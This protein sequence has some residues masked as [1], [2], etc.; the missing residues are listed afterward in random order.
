MKMLK[1]GGFTL[2]ELMITVA[3][4]AILA[5][6]AVPNFGPFVQGGRMDTLQDRLVASL[7]LARS[8]AISSRRS[9]TLCPRSD[10]VDSCGDD[11]G[12][13]WSVIRDGTAIHVEEP[14]E[15]GV[16]LSADRSITFDTGGQVSAGTSCF[17]VSDGDATTEDRYVQVLATGRLRSWD[18][19]SEED[20]V[21]GNG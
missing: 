1:H 8:E 9:V 4:L 17:T 12:L 20:A 14:P 15:S 13:G 11:W 6:V 10:D 3:I 18:R 19:D 21:C 7:S 5:M 16:S 2:V